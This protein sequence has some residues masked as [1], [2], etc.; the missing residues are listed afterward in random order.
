MYGAFP[1]FPPLGVGEG[2]Y[3]VGGDLALGKT[4]RDGDLLQEGLLQTPG[5]ADSGQILAPLLCSW[6]DVWE[7][8]GGDEPDPAAATQHPGKCYWGFSVER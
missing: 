7:K 5:Q 4:G 8:Q 2:V 6:G 1:I 3:W